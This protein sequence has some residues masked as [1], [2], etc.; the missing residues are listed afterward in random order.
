MSLFPVRKNKEQYQQNIN[1]KHTH[2]YNV[3]TPPIILTGRP[4][5]FLEMSASI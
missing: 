5:Y 4:L 1:F 2:D 3:L